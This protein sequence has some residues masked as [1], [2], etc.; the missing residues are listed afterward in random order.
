MIAQSRRV[1]N[2]RMNSHAVWL[3]IPVSIMEDRDNIGM[4]VFSPS[5]ENDI[6]AQPALV[7]TIR[8]MGTYTF[9]RSAT[10][11]S[12]RGNIPAFRTSGSISYRESII[13]NYYRILRPRLLCHARPLL[14]S[15]LAGRP[16]RKHFTSCRNSVWDMWPKY[17]S[18]WE[19]HLWL[20][21]FSGACL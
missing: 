10:A 2:E 20:I 5:A 4:F 8:L 7:A 21:V 9:L 18:F 16:F 11:I 17:A 13:L 1:F 6:E 15:L 3:F 14:H 12:V 19:G